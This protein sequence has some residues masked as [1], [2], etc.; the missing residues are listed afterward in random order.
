VNR[1]TP[2]TVGQALGDHLEAAMGCDAPLHA[3]GPCEGPVFLLHRDAVIGGDEPLSSVFV[4]TDRDAIEAV[5]REPD[6][7]NKIFGSYAG[8]S[9]SQ[10]EAELAEKAWVVCPAKPSDVFSS[11]PT[12]WKSLHTRAH[13]SRYVDPD[14]VPDDPSV[15]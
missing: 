15:N 13:L 3:G 6:K 2:I 1:P 4:T 8:W 10:L 12:L 7:P 9:P 11:D 14:R 5:L